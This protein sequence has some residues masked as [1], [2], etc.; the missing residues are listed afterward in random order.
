MVA[1]GGATFTVSKG[2]GSVLLHRACSFHFDKTLPYFIQCQS[3]HDR[4]CGGMFVFAHTFHTQC[5]QPGTPLYLCICDTMVITPSLHSQ[6]CFNEL[7]IERVPSLSADS[8]L[9]EQ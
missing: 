9:H 4:V 6:F 7:V 2:T 5:P 3:T 1:D 8:L